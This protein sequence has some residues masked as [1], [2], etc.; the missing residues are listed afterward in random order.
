M[1]FIETGLSGCLR[2]ALEPRGDERGFFSRTFCAASFAA[3]GL[4]TD[5]VQ[6]SISFSKERGT[7]RGMHF[8]RPPHAEAKLVRCLRGEIFD[9][10]IDLRVGSSTQGRW[11]GVKLSAENFEQ[12]YIPKGF[13]HGFQT[14]SP[15]CLIDYRISTAYAPEAGCGVRWNDPAFAIDWPL[16][17]TVMNDKDQSWPDFQG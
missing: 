10:V 13:A 2:V 9:V 12:L 1:R 8:Q 16:V 6:H 14:L 3:Q 7:L 17:P 11:I 4:E 15:D 5:F